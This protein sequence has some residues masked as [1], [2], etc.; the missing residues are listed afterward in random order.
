VAVIK[1]RVSEETLAQLQM[2]AAV[3]GKSVDEMAEAALR[4]ASR[5]ESGRTS[6]AMDVNVIVRL[7]A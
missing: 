1:V 5:S 7:G 4:M 6:L 2:L 3:E